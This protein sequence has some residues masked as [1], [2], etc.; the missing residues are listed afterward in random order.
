[1]DKQS[2]MLDE[3]IKVAKKYG[4]TVSDYMI[5]NPRIEIGLQK[6][7]KYERGAGI[8]K[9]IVTKNLEASKAAGV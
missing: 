6:D 9:S 1:M 8:K 2:T 3:L 4:Y 7:G 5:D